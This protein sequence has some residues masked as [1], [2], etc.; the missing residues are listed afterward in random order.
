[1]VYG[2]YS[3]ENFQPKTT[4]EIFFFCVRASAAYNNNALTSADRVGGHLG[5]QNSSLESNSRP[6]RLS[7]SHARTWSSDQRN[8][9]ISFPR[10]I[11]IELV[12]LPQ[13]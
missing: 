10:E 4:P 1:V 12:R 13:T 8:V 3:Y 2:L 11:R 5:L 9:I 6:E 7:S